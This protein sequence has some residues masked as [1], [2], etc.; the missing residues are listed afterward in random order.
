MIDYRKSEST[1][2][3]VSDALDSAALAAV[4]YQSINAQQ[5]SKYA[6][7]Y[8]WDIIPK[9]ENITL[10][11]G[12]SSDKRVVLKAETRS[13]TSIARAIGI[14]EI[15]SQEES[16]AI[17]TKGFVVCA[18]ALDPSMERAFEVRD[19][20][21]FFAPNCTVQVNSKHPKAAVIGTGGTAT[22]K[23]F[24]VSGG[25]QGPFIP[26]ANTQCGA[27]M[28]PYTNRV[29]PNTG[30]CKDQK[31]IDDILGHWHAVS[32]GVRLSPGTYCGGLYLR[33]HKVHF[34][35]G[36]YTFKDGPLILNSGARVTG[37]GVSFVMSGKNSFVRVLN[38]STINVAAPSSGALKG[39]VFFQDKSSQTQHGT[40][41][42]R[43][44]SVFQSGAN[45][46]ITGTV[47][48]P[49]QQLTF[50]DGSASITQAPATSFI[51]NNIHLSRGAALNVAV[52]HR[53]A[54]LPPIE[55]RAEEGA[56]LER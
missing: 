38:G 19:G 11:V 13:P 4:T 21:S 27:V 36:T 39:L 54:G 37:N 51:A 6:E 46:I 17:L 55:P 41:A 9:T 3:R 45:M 23:D 53:A 15:V 48:L 25:V 24:C 42:T 16:S 18:L 7:E 35:P 44:V 32:K 22:A 52:D 29:P 50:I 28:D 30:A 31:E 1:R 20:A 33:S 8:F 12:E 56:R 47:Y 40:R 26:S 5:R 34:E 49:T 14:S 2:T 10:A 43:L